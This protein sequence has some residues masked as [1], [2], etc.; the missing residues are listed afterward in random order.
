MQM[1]TIMMM[2]AVV[3]ILTPVKVT[4]VR[5]PVA[6]CMADM[7]LP[8]TTNKGLRPCLQISWHCVRQCRRHGHR[9]TLEGTFSVQ[10]G[11]QSVCAITPM[12]GRQ[13]AWHL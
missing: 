2:P 1:N 12:I 8:H 5:M 13:H 11:L 7:M 6:I 3:G 4:A 9:P 10:A